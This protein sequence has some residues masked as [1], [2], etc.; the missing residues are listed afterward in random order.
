MQVD[1]AHSVRGVER[2]VDRL[3]GFFQAG[4]QEDNPETDS[5]STA[6]T[7]EA[8]LN[9][10]SV[11]YANEIYAMGF[12]LSL[13]E[14]KIYERIDAMLKPHSEEEKKKLCPKIHARILDDTDETYGKNLFENYCNTKGYEYE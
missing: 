9:R 11:V 1:S 7:E 13:S 6:V 10:L 14:I 4:R 8:I 2:T 12:N 5:S 3:L